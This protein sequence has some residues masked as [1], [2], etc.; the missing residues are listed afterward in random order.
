MDFVCRTWQIPPQ[1]QV[2]RYLS[3]RVF[4]SLKL[5][6]TLRR[7]GEEWRGGWPRP[8]TLEQFAA[9]SQYSQNSLVAGNILHG[10]KDLDYPVWWQNCAPFSFVMK[11]NP[12]HNVRNR[13]RNHKFKI[14]KRYALEPLYSP[15]TPPHGFFFD[16]RGSLMWTKWFQ[17]TY[18]CERVWM[19]EGGRE[20]GGWKE[21]IPF[22][23]QS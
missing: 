13:T 20:G 17:S 15:C 22:H 7:Y 14:Q 21:N 1:P 9:S 2:V 8:S 4:L 19:E 11:K 3:R 12:Y 16:I 6:S 5:Y 10:T 23:F 18:N